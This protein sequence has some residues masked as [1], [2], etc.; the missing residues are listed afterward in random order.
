MATK[1]KNKEIKIKKIED[2]KNIKNRYNVSGSNDMKEE[3][4]DSSK[5]SG[6]ENKDIINL[7][8]S[9]QEKKSNSNNSNTI[10]EKSEELYK[11]QNT[12]SKRNDSNDENNN[13]SQS[14]NQ[15][16]NSRDKKSLFES[17]ENSESSEKKE[18]NNSSYLNSKHYEN[19]NQN[20]YENGELDDSNEENNDQN[21]LGK[22]NPFMTT[23][24]FMQIQPH[25]SIFSQ[26]I[27]NLRERIY[28]NTK[29]CLIHKS[30]LQYSE[31]LMRERANSIVKDMVEKIFNIRKMF[32]DSKKEISMIISETDGLILNLANIQDSNKRDI[33]ECQHKIHN[34]EGQ[35]GYKLL[36]K[37]NYSFMK[38]TYS[39]KIDNKI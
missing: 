38:K 9:K 22:K 29:K 39:N 11:N 26:Q 15:E 10:K 2:S 36:G 31:N 5:L 18:N 7:N 3:S 37:P 19:S 32:L 17:K 13:K 25:F 23:G 4:K 24:K 27:E 20:E 28:Q 8:T 14:R 16:E 30:S 12:N 35:I 21:Y 6:D 1:E 33:N 34:C